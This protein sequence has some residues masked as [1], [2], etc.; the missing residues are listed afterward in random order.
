MVGRGQHSHTHRLNELY[1]G[2]NDKKAPLS[3]EVFGDFSASL[4]HSKTLLVT[5][6]MLRIWEGL[7]ET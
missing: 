3:D 6:E 5:S 1:A 7:E 2:T 4:G